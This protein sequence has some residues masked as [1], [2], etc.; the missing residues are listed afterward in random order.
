MKKF[1]LFLCVFI[2][3]SVKAETLNET[4]TN[5]FKEDTIKINSIPLEYYKTSEYYQG[6]MLYG[7]EESCLTEILRVVVKSHFN[8]FITLEKGLKLDPACYSKT[9]TCG[10]ALSNGEEE[11]GN[12]FKIEFVGNYNEDIFKEVSKTTKDIKKNYYLADMAY[13][14]QLLHYKSEDGDILE[15]EYDNTKV[16]KMFPEIKKDLELNDEYS[17]VPVSIGFGFSPLLHGSGGVIITYYDDVAYNVSNQTGYNTIQAVFVSDKTPNNDNDLIKEAS[18]RI[19]EYINNDDIKFEIKVDDQ[20]IIDIYGDLTFDVSHTLND[21]FND[22]KRYVA[23]PYMIEIDGY[24]TILFII[25]V[26]ESRIKKLE[27]NSINKKTGIEISTYSSSVP[28]DTSLKIEDVTNN[29]KDKDIIK[30]FDINLFSILKNY[31]VEKIKEGVIV[32]IPI[33]NDID[34]EI[35][36]IKDDGTREKIDYEIEVIE[37]QKYAKFITDHFSLYAMT[38]TMNQDLPNTPNT[39]DNLGNYISIFVVS[40]LVLILSFSYKIKT[41]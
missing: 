7:S 22:N 11:V 36:Y 24:E 21:Y 27:I 20:K 13:I 8:K 39:K 17:Y 10:V 3:I 41:N 15:V 25:P 29:M 38:K 40:I 19:K 16:L 5:I 35:N 33:Y 9:M 2:P 18:R 4:F 32:R 26:N 31:F 37:G 34:F 30:A 12:T 14:N 28:I 6:C 23:K 1:L